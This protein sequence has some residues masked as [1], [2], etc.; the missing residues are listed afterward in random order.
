MVCEAAIHEFFFKLKKM[1][2][3]KKIESDKNALTNLNRHRVQGAS[4][5]QNR[6]AQRAGEV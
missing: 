3:R 1:N 4:P 6:R 2:E 5:I